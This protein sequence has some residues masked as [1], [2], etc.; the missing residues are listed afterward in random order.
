MVAVFIIGQF[1]FRL[2]QPENA[3][4]VLIIILPDLIP[5][6]G[7]RIR[8]CGVNKSRLA[9]LVHPLA[10]V[11]PGKIPQFF[12]LF[13]ILAL[14]IHGGP[15]GY[16]QF[17]SH[18]LQ[19]LHHGFQIRPVILIEFPVALMRPME[20]VR[21]DHINRKASALVFPRHLQQFFLGLIA[22]LAL[23]ESH[24][25]I[26]HHRHLARGI[27]I[28]LFDLGGRI[29]CGD[30]IIHLS[31]GMCD[32]FR[33]VL[34]K[35]DA[36]DRRI[37]PEHS[38]A[39]IGQG[40]GNA[41]LG[42]PVRQFH[43]TALHIQIRLLILAHTVDFLPIL[44]LEPHRQLVILRSGNR[45][46]STRRD[47][48][49]AVELSFHLF[50][51]PVPVIFLQKQFSLLVIKFQLACHHQFTANVSVDEYGAFPVRLRLRLHFL[52]RKQ[53]ILIPVL[54]KRMVLRCTHAQAVLPPRLD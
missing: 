52:R 17:D 47:L 43:H 45:R 8:I 31:G 1:R 20:I 14:L 11:V 21:H 53:R 27:C 50:A 23:P 25:I 40:K 39:L 15:D 33:Q 49:R 7:S 38:I 3:Y 32:P 10:E 54:H 37:V 42:I 4:A 6:K 35:G 51:E 34:S 19:F 13:I 46:K 12:H 2:I 41:G 26:W 36:S 18:P 5:D 24:S 48:Q 28:C 29:P 16:H 44:G 9:Q 22:K 30:P